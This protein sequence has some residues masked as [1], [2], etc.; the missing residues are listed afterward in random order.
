MIEEADTP[1]SAP[2]TP[3]QEAQPP[4][5]AGLL[6]VGARVQ[7]RKPHPCGGK[8]WKVVRVGAEVGM[9][10][11]TCGRKVDLPRAEAGKRIARILD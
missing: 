10:C 2:A 8:T 7:L 4:A 1:D 9:V 3:D 6:V 11:D 5:A